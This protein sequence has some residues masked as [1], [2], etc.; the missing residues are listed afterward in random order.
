MR[1]LASRMRARI[2]PEMG[3]MATRTVVQEKKAARTH[4]DTLIETSPRR[5]TSHHEH[6][7]PCCFTHAL[8]YAWPEEAAP[9]LARSAT[10]CARDGRGRPTHTGPDRSDTALQPR[11]HVLQRV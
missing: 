1:A 5:K 9:A 7:V 6:G 4:S 11:L 3:T 10:V 2:W 8:R